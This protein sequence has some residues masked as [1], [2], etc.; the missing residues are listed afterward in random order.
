MATYYVFS[1]KEILKQN[2]ELVELHK[3]CIKT[4]LVSQSC[5]APV[6]N[7][8][9]KLYDH[10]LNERNILCY[11]YTPL[12]LFVRA[13]VLNQLEL[14]TTYRFIQDEKKQKRKRT[15]KKRI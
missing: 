14:V 10:Y 8:F 9:F 3:R 15:R 11:F 6:R 5:R 7:K 1:Q 12:P 4:Y 2:K 13:L